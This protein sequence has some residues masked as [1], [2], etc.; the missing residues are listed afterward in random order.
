MDEDQTVEQILNSDSCKAGFET[1]VEKAEL[2]FGKK[3]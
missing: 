2:N 1:I 3:K